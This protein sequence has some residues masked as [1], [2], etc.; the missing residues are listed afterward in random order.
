MMDGFAHVSRLA[1]AAV[2]REVGTEETGVYFALMTFQLDPAGGDE[3]RYAITGN[4]PDAVML[5][6]L[7]KTVERM[8]ARAI[9]IEHF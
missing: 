2:A 5:Q 3:H 6:I 8:K 7:E 4:L 9:N 1:A